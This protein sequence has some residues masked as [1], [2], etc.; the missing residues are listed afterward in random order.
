MPASRYRSNRSEEEGSYSYD[1]ATRTVSYS[2][3]Y[4]EE[5]YSGRYEA[6]GERDDGRHHIENVTQVDDDDFVV[7]FLSE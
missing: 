1:A 7:N 3:V 2:G 4:A 5:G 6:A